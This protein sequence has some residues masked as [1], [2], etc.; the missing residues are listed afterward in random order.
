MR[1]RQAIHEYLDKGDQL[2]SKLGIDLLLGAPTDRIMKPAE[3]EFLPDNLMMALDSCTNVPLVLS[4][5][6]LYPV[7]NS[8][9]KKEWFTPLF[10]FSVLL[11][12]F[13]ALHFFFRRRLPVM[14][15]GFDGILFF[16]TGLLGFLLIFMWVATDHSMTKNNYNLLWALPTHL[17][18][19]FFI[20]SP[21]SW[22]RKYFGLT[23]LAG[24]LLLI[25]WGFLPQQMNNALLPFVLLLIFRA[26]VKYFKIN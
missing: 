17:F 5:Q 6:N 4:S 25:C 11:I 22:V 7:D 20:N 21:K 2:W 23:A 10:F 26:A 13:I 16:S 19:S 8:A 24:I 14:V 3:Q 18:I 12:A 9:R 15:N 1:F